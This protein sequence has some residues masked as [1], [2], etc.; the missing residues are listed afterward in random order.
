MVRHWIDAFDDRNPVYLGASAALDQPAGSILAPPAMLQTWTMGRPQIE[1]IAERGGSAGDM[2][3]D[4]PLTMLT[5]AG[6][7]GTLATNSELGTNAT[8][9][10]TEKWIS[11]VGAGKAVVGD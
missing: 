5:S 7:G 11:A 9:A 4:N 1:G 3:A 6:F 8:R 2:Q 10:G